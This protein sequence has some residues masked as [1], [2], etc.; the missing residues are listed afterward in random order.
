MQ[1]KSEKIKALIQSRLNVRTVNEE[2][3]QFDDLLKLFL[4]THYQYQSKLK[5]FQQ[6]EDGNWF[7]GLNRNIFTFKHL[8][9]NYIQDNEENCS[10]KP[11]QISES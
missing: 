3:S 6:I 1:R 8:V 4:D 2:F 9:H 7:D 11:S 10:I 5:D